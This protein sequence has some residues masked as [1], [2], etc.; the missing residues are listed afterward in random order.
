MKQEESMN[1]QYDSKEMNRTRTVSISL[2]PGAQLSSIGCPK[3]GY[4]SRGRWLFPLTPTLFL[5]N[6]GHVSC[7]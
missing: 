5:Y 3:Y 1:E 6:V 2:H 7:L 4:A